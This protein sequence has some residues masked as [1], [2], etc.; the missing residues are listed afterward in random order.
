[1]GLACVALWVSGSRS[2]LSRKLAVLASPQ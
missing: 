1:M 2:G